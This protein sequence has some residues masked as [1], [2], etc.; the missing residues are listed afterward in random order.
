MNWSRVQGLTAAPAAVRY[1]AWIRAVF[2]SRRATT[3]KPGRRGGCG[4]T[5]PETS[6]CGLAVGL[7]GSDLLKHERIAF[8]RGEVSKKIE[9]RD[10]VPLA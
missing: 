9:Y 1:G 10:V 4:Q 6:E 5:L 2:A 3:I 7:R 8:T